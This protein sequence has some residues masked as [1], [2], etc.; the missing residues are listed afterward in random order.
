MPAIEKSTFN[1][2]NVRKGI[3]GVRMLSIGKSVYNVSDVNMI[4]FGQIVEEKTEDNWKWYRINWFNRKPVNPYDK[5][6]Y[7]PETGWF[8]CDTV[9]AF[10]PSDMMAQLDEMII[11]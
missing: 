8:R 3:K 6:N 11:G 5:P 9:K 4:S 2:S 7:N 10:E 1:I